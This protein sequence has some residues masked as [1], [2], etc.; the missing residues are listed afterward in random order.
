[1]DEAYQDGSILFYSL[2]AGSTRGALV[3]NKSEGAQNVGFFAQDELA[4]SDR[5]SFVIGGR[6]DKIVYTYRSFLPA[7]L[8]KQ[9]SKDFDR[10]S[11]KLGL[12]WMLGK[13]NSLYANVGGG[14]EAPAGNETDQPPTGPIAGALLN[15][16]LDAITSTTYEIGAKSLGM[17]VFDTPFKVGYDVAA[18][19]TNVR[20]EI[21]PYS[22]GRYYQTAAKARRNGVELGLNVQSAHGLFANAAFTLNDHKYSMYI[23][24]SSVIDMSKEGK[25]VNLSGNQVMGV[26]NLMS[27]VELGSEIPGLRTARIKGVMEHSGKYFANDLNTIVIPAYTIF[28]VTAELRSPIVAANG[29]GVRGFVTVH[30]VADTKYIGSAFLNPDLVDGQPAV[31]EPGMPRAVTVSF[32]L[33]RIR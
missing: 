30:N 16:L 12:T 11:P 21:I 4:V 17:M 7:A 15:P 20:N 5:L 13:S 33:G 27:N 28:N 9:Q 8:V 25:T 1:M 29:W 3:D 22:G 23:V 10:L 19:H 6:Y 26:P 18:Y 14:I 32:S 31:F 2:A 24:D